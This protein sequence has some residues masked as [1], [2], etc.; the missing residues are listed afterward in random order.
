MNKQRSLDLNVA[1]SVYLEDNDF[2]CHFIYCL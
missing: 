1:Y 2:L